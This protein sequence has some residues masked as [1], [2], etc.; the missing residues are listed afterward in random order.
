MDLESSPWDT[1]SP[2]AKDLV[3]RL[4]ERDVRKRI[5][6]AD[7]AEHVWV[8]EGGYTRSAALA[9]TAIAR[10][11]RFGTS[12]ALRQA[13]LRVMARELDAM[14]RSST[15]GVS[16]DL[17]AIEALF[18]KMDPASKGEARCVERRGCR[19][20][21]GLWTSTLAGMVSDEAPHVLC[22]R[23][24][25]AGGGGGA[26]AGGRVRALRG[27]VG[28][29]ARTDGPEQHRPGQPGGLHC[30]PGRLEG[31]RAVQCTLR[32][33]SAAKAAPS[34]SQIEL[35]S[36]REGP[37]RTSLP[38]SV[39]V[40]ALQLAPSTVGGGQGRGQ[41]DRTCEERLPGFSWARGL[42]W[43]EGN[44]AHGRP[45]RGVRPFVVGRTPI[46]MVCRSIAGVGTKLA[47]PDLTRLRLCLQVCLMEDDG[48]VCR[49][50][51]C[52]QVKSGGSI[53]VAAILMLALL[54][55]ADAPRPPEVRC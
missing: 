10:L 32:V 40:P 28:A 8:R 18:D 27:G 41:L 29:N 42:R 4:L 1:I 36:R 54:G 47:C 38:L 31:A 17:E 2:L 22:A 39:C 35:L 6:A 45:G 43:G 24:G 20:A 26:A 52:A 7:A 12:N 51:V 44:C 9:G 5:S 50:A 16:A 25:D 49:T 34:E 11:Q 33:L 30:K 13:A 48:T 21:G 23:A 55:S 37:S 19:P 53:R 15:G 46:W 3:R 14:E